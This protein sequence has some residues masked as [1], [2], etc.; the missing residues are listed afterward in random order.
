M[1]SGEKVR[2]AEEAH[3]PAGRR[4]RLPGAV[5]VEDVDVLVERCPVAHLDG[6]VDGRG[7]G[8]QGGDT[9]AVRIGEGAQRPG[10]SL[11]SNLVEVMGRFHP[12]SHLVVIAP[13]EGV[14]LQFVD[15]VHDLCSDWPRSQ[16][17]RRAPRVGRTSRGA[18]RPAR[19]PAPPDWSG[20]R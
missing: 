3:P 20:Y 5:L 10:R 11:G 16:R 4:Q 2:V 9:F 8:G 13:N 14:G 12:G 15:A 6:L 1:F 17:G 19:R 18:P 7:A